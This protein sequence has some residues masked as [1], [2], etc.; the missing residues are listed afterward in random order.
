MLLLDYP[1]DGGAG[2]GDGVAAAA[3]SEVDFVADFVIEV[4]AG[5]VE[6]ASNFRPR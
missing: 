5:P 1:F 2:S 6:L 3:G 4:A